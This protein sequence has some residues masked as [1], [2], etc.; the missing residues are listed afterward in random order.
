MFHWDFSMT[1]AKRWEKKND[2]SQLDKLAEKVK[3]SD[4]LKGKIESSIRRVEVECQRLDQ[5]YDRL[6]KQDK[7]LFDKAVECYKEHDQKRASVY[8]VEIAENRKL[9][10]MVLQAKLALEVVALR[11]RTSTELGDVAVSLMPVVDTLNGIQEGIATIA[12][13]AEKGIGDMDGLLNGMI[14]DLGLTVTDPI[15]FESSNEDTSKIL[16]EA[17]TIAESK[18]NNSFPTLSGN[19]FGQTIKEDESTR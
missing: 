14:I 8:S 17:Q 13:Q 19:P 9:Q 2:S 16:D 4:P 10:K 3:P 15:S 18:I 5:A 11:A 6:Q 12:P 7:I 1:F